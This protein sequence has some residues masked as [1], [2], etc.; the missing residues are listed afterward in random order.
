MV[1]EV[2]LPAMTSDRLGSLKVCTLERK[3][4]QKGIGIY[5]IF[6]L[7]SNMFSGI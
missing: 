5:V 7:L 2:G 4:G 3:A 6:F 1:V